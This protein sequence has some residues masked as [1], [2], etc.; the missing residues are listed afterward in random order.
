MTALRRAQNELVLDPHQ[1]ALGFGDAGLTHLVGGPLHPYALAFHC[2]AGRA[3]AAALGAEFSPDPPGVCRGVLPDVFAV[4]VR[5][6]AGDP[7]AD[8]FVVVV[9]LVFAVEGCGDL[10]VC[11]YELVDWVRWVSLGFGYLAVD[12]VEAAVGVFQVVCLVRVVRVPAVLDTSFRRYDVWVCLG[13]GGAG[14]GFPTARERRIGCW[15]R[16]FGCWCGRGLA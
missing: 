11:L 14:D 6:L 3:G 9:F 10:F 7:V 2:G 13:G 4:C 1:G 8:F 12:V 16:R 5:D 15:E